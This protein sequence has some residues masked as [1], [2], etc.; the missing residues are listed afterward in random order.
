MVSEVSRAMREHYEF[1]DELD[2]AGA[3]AL[4]VNRTGLRLLSILER[5]GPMTMGALTEAAGLRKSAMTAAIDRL[6][7]AGFI[8]REVNS[9]DR[10]SLMVALSESARKRI[11]M[12]YGPLQMET[13]EFLE[14]FTDSELE[15]LRRFLSVANT[16]QKSHTALIQLPREED[17]AKRG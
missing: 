7:E 9:S 16:A 3:I 11:D 14:E 5:S 2:N 15:L 1:T 4:G 12:V 8:H 13:R 10:R 17:D 6:V